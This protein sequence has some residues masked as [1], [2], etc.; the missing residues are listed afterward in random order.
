[1]WSSW[2]QTF[3]TK[4]L[5][6]QF[7]V[8]RWYSVVEVGL[9]LRQPSHNLP[10]ISQHLL[11][12]Q[13]I[14]TLDYRRNIC[15]GLMSDPQWLTFV[16]PSSGLDVLFKC[17]VQMTISSK[18]TNQ[19]FSKSTSTTCLKNLCHVSEALCGPKGILLNWNRPRVETTNAFRSFEHS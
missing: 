2:G 3:Y 14:W 4:K 11:H 6:P 9:Q 12:N 19:N 5:S 16:V 17:G 10:S 15:L 13:D 18:S 8:I 1:M 7:Y